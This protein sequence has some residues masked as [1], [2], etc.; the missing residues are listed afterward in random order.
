M[1]MKSPGG[2]GEVVAQKEKKNGRTSEGERNVEKT[3]A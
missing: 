1:R 3:G 2:P